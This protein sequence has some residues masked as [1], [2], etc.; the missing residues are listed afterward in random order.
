MLLAKERLPSLIEVP[1]IIILS[2]D[3]QTYD[4]KYLRNQ[5]KTEPFL[6]LA[7]PKIKNYH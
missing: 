3:V 1:K 7:M 2:N 4:I 6:F 5:R